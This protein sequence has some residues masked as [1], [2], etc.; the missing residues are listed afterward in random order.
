MKNLLFVLVAGVILSSCSGLQVVVDYD[1]TVDFT[2]LK[3]FE[4]YGWAAESDKILNQLEKD[5]IERAF[6][7]EFKSRGLEYVESDGD[8]VVVLYIMTQDKTSILA[9]APGLSSN[10]MRIVS[11]AMALYSVCANAL[12]ALS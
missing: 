12:R 3:T 4:Y 10:L 7:D 9:S 8:M 1:K 11:W 6:G 2:K 5:R